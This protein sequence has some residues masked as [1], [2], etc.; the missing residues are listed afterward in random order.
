MTY[1]VPSF[2]GSAYAV[3]PTPHVACTC[4][5]ERLNARHESSMHNHPRE[6]GRLHIAIYHDCE[7]LS[8]SKM[9]QRSITT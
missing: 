7:N 3:L 1:I 9:V 6:R 8:V 5:E 4:A 2:L